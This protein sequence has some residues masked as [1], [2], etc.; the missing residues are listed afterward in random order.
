[1]TQPT[2]QIMYPKATLLQNKPPTH[3]M[4]SQVKHFETTQMEVGN[5][6]LDQ[7]LVRLIAG[8]WFQWKT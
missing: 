5:T 4:Y 1:M 2:N 7:S 8:C 6:K 3:P